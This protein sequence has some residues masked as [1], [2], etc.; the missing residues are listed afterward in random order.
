MPSSAQLVIQQILG[1]IDKK[2]RF[3]LLPHA[4]DEAELP[5]QVFELNLGTYK[6]KW[7]Q[8]YVKQ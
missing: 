8:N 7:Y 6:L 2:M 4:H 3:K 5:Q 1:G